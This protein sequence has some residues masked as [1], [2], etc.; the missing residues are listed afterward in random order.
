[1]V[2]SKLVVGKP[3][4]TLQQGPSLP[5]LKAPRALLGSPQVAHPV[6]EPK[7][8]NRL[9]EPKV[10]NRLEE[11]KVVNRPEVH[12]VAVAA[13][14]KVASRLAVLLEVAEAKP[15]AA[16]QGEKPVVLLAVAVVVNLNQVPATKEEEETLV[17]LHRAQQQRDR[18]S[19]RRTMLRTTMIHRHTLRRSVTGAVREVGQLQ[20]PEVAEMVLLKRHHRQLHARVGPMMPKENSNPS[21]KFG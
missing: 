11:P 9:E 18:R 19:L 6:E 1:M 2:G 14:R 21:T 20:V 3:P 10:V 5:L 15:L 16:V 12:Q 17:A 7:V 4:A 13:E 8:V